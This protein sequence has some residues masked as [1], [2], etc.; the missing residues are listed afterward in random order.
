L[1]SQFPG[2]GGKHAAADQVLGIL[3]DRLGGCIE[4]GLQLAAFLFLLVQA[5]LVGEQIFLDTA[6]NICRAEEI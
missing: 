3:H 5:G 4:I 6:A 2:F 1:D